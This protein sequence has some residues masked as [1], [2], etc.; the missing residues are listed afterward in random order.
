MPTMTHPNSTQRITVAAD[1]VPMY[2]SQGWR[3]DPPP[4]YS[5]GAREAALVEAALAAPGD[6]E[7]SGPTKGSAK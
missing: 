2:A 1:R 5:D 3:V 7:T 6:S 4:T